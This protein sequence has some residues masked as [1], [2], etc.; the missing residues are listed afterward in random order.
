MVK[1][2]LSGFFSGFHGN[3]FW[4]HEDGSYN[5]YKLYSRRVFQAND[6]LNFEK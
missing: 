4:L 5:Q 2:K 3:P 6:S 1:C